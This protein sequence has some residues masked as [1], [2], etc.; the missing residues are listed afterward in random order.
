MS[1][2]EYESDQTFYTSFQYLTVFDTLLYPYIHM[3]H[4]FMSHLLNI[5]VTA[6]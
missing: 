3:S 6:L 1:E 4:S 2:L 5:L